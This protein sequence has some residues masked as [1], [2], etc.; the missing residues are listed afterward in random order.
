MKIDFLQFDFSYLITL[1]SGGACWQGVKFIYPDIKNYFEKRRKAKQILYAS[2][3][4]AIKS[5]DELFG[6]LESLSREDFASFI[7]KDNSISDSPEHNQIYVYYLIGQF[8]ATLENIRIQSNYTSIA[9]LKKGRELIRFIETIESRKFRLLDRSK[10]R[11]IGEAM[12][13]NSGDKFQVM[14]LYFFFEKIKSDETFRNWIREIDIQFQLSKKTNIR[15]RILV[16]GV[17]VAMF[18]DHFDSENKISR[19]RDI[20]L[21]KLRPESIQLIK[22]ILLKH[23]LSFIKNPKRYYTK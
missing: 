2:M 4:L 16:Y 15:Q 6:K 12:I 23:Y 1:I 20:Y 8:W 10:Q 17:I 13:I 18:L 9:R 21:I 11:I 3:D 14:P 22:N 5:S 19:R 7:N